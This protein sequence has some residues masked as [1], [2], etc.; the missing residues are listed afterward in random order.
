[1][2][3]APVVKTVDVKC[4]PA[5]AFELFTARMGGWWPSSHHTGAT[6]F[7]EVV[8]EPKAGGRWFERDAAG[9]ETQWGRVLTWSPPDGVLLAWQLNADFKFDPDF[10]TELE[11]TFEA[12][13]LGTRVRLEH[14]DLER[15]GESAERIAE[16]LRGGWPTIIGEF[17]AF[18]DQPQ[19][20]AQGA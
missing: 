17:A 1:M 6:P 15:F 19:T 8:V 18:A 9:A 14:R 10:E 11:I 20:Q 16:M 7:E 12:L 2:T 5:R 4:G 13:A 3:I